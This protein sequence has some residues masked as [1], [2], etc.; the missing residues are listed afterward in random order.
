MPSKSKKPVKGCVGFFYKGIIGQGK[1]RAG[2]SEDKEPSDLYDELLT[3]YGEGLSFKYVSCEDPEAVFKKFK[4][5]NKTTHI[6]DDL[7]TGHI[8]PTEQSLKKVSGEKIA[9]GWPK[10]P[11]RKEEDS[12]EDKKSSK[13]KSDEESKSKSK[14]GSKKTQHESDSDEDEKQSKSKSK[15]KSSSSSKKTQHESD[16]DEDEKQSKSKSKSKSSS[17]SKKTQ[18]DS[19]DEDD[20]K[21]AKGKGKNPPKKSK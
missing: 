12:E 20:S 14:S 2:Y 19:D 13:K 21:Q 9:H 11:A 1:F 7:Y 15:S 17:S 6:N 8:E 18:Q 4:T 10:R 3:M 16:S 5:D